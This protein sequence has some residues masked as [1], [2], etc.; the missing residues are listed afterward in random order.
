MPY[1]EILDEA[2]E[3]NSVSTRLEGL[4]ELNPLVSEALTVVAANIR[5]TAMLMAV[6]VRIKGPQPD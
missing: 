4:A 1:L 2:D 3:L 5:N 6:L